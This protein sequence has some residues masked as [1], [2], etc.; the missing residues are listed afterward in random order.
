[1][2]EWQRAYWKERGS[3]RWVTSGD[4][5]TKF[6]YANATIRHRQNTILSLQADD[7]EMITSH[8]DKA[9][10]LWESYKQRLGRSEFTHI[11]FD[12]QE[13]QVRAK[14]SGSFRWVIYK[15]RD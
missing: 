6:F 1:L 2:L 11:Y 4:A 7:G 13:L 5:K 12:L 10:L 3:I 9:K 15:G 14:K 8:E